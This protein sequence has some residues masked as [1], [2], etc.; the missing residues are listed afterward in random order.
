MTAVTPLRPCLLLAFALGIMDSL[1]HL[2]DSVDLC[3]MKAI[4]K[5]RVPEFK[6]VCSKAKYPF[7]EFKDLNKQGLRDYILDKEF[8]VSAVATHLAWLQ[9]R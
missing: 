2:T 1:T 3:R 9:G 7:V 6:E 4:N 8:Q 5:L